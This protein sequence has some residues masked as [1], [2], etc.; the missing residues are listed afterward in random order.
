[1]KRIRAVRLLSVLLVPVLFA[2]A[3]SQRDDDDATD[4]SGGDSGGES[5]DS[6]IA[7]DDCLVDPTTEIEGDTIKLVSSFP[8]SGVTAA[9]AEIARGWRS[10]FEMV[11]AEGGVDVGDK[12]FQLEFEDKDD[13]YD[14]AQTVSNIEELLGTESE[15]AFGAFSVVGT[16][17][18]IA[19]RDSLGEQ[20]VPNLFAATGSP[21]WGNPDYPWLIGGTIPPYSLESFVFVELLKKEKPDA[22]VAMLVQ[23][24]DFGA[25][26]RD[27]FEKAIEGTDIELVKVETYPPGATSDVSAQITSLAGSGADVFFDGATLIPCPDALTKAAQAGWEREITWVSGTCIS[28]TLM[29][30]AGENAQGVYS[31]TNIKDPLD[32]QYAEDE[33]MLLY[34]EQVAQYEPEADLENGIVAYGW[35]QA[36]LFVEALEAAEAPTRLAVME[37]VRDLDVGD[38]I[39]LLA[40]GTGVTTSDDDLY[41]GERFNLVQYEF[42]SAE[43]KNHFNI[44]E[45]YDYEGQT[46][47][48]TPEELVTGG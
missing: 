34:K 31:M 45:A 26:Y 13:E 37:S 38:D 29:G 6:S 9:F 28:K 15:N 3:C 19:I 47:E 46:G 17:N 12:T 41:M 42:Q 20:C 35:T 33:A 27:S 11:N 2:S 25:G 16:S 7:T 14:S 1:M 32:P 10:Y 22:K 30:L 8:Q 24:D 39:G 23:A 36:A 21:A 18:N 48:L 44:I 43:A 5:A 40:E 4:D